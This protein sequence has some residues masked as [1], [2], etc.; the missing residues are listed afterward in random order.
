M[1]R[2]QFSQSAV[3]DWQRLRDFTA[4]NNEE[5]AVRVALRIRDIGT[6]VFPAK[7]RPVEVAGVRELVAGNMSFATY[8]VKLENKLSYE[9]GTVKNIGICKMTNG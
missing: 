8:T 2:I 7:G 1:I 3:A 6:L 9:C 5:A 4:A